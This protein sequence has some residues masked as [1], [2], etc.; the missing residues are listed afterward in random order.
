[1]NYIIGIPREIKE[2][3]FRVSLV[4]EEVEKLV[5]NN[6]KVYLQTGAGIG[7]YYTD[8]DYIKKGA[9]ICEDIYKKANLIVKVKEPQEREYDLI[10]DNH[11]IMTFFHFGGNLKL[12]EIM[13]NKGAICI[14]Y[15][16]IK[17][18]DGIYPILSPMSII[19]G[20]KAMIE[21]HKIIND[22][23]KEITIIGVGNAGKASILKAKE[24]GYNKINL[25]D[26][27]YNKIESYKKEG[28]KIYE[29]NEVNLNLLLKKS[30]IVIGSIYNH[31][32]TASKLI[33]NEMLLS[34]PESSIFMDIAIDQGGMTEQSIATTI[35]NPIIKFNH[36]NLYCVPNIPSTVPREASQKLSSAIYPYINMVLTN[37]NIKKIIEP[38]TDNN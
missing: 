31:N 36:V 23:T 17:T 20:T 9:I 28:L 15:E 5:N 7:A 38:F 10:N 33:T 13:K 14:P 8:E 27:D 1:M 22:N 6:Y 35:T 19:A 4:P 25:I 24:L 34:M 18:D 32:K 37:T 26:K 12:K 16:I 21:A 29:M 11:T 30:F 2:S 3:E